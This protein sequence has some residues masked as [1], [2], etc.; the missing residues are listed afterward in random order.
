MVVKHRKLD[1]L[2]KVFWFLCNRN[3]FFK[4]K[5]PTLAGFFKY[6]MSFD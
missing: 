6:F 3:S 5:N 4:K 2:A 1:D